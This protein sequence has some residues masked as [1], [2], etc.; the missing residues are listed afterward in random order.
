M[1][2]RAFSALLASLALLPLSAALYIRF[3]AIAPTTQQ[4]NLLDVIALACAA[5]IIGFAFLA[6][7]DHRTEFEKRTAQ[8]HRRAMQRVRNANELDRARNAA[9][10]R[11]RF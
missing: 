5:M 6:C 7:C 10:S 1:L 3:N 2:F 11:N 9:R 8:R 4:L